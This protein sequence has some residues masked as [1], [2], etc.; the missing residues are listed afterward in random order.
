MTDAAA[1]IKKNLKTKRLVI[2]TKQTIKSLKLGKLEK[3]FITVNCPQS[4][5]RDI[6][7]YC[8]ISGCKI[9]NL[10]I[11]NEELGILCKKQFAISAAGLLRS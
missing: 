5:K 2:G 3:V 6:E 11:Q 9:E 1:D 7:H 4:V 10:G 8:S